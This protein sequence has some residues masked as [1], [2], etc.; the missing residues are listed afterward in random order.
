MILEKEIPR[1]F[2]RAL[3]ITDSED[4]ILCCGSLYMIGEIR[5]YILSL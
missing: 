3:E 1:A 2:D 5:E 4:M